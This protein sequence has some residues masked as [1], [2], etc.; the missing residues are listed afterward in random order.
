MKNVVVR[1]KVKPER[2]AEH[3]ALIAR[4]FA[5]LAE[6]RPKDLRYEVFK[7]ADGLS[8]VHLAT[9]SATPNPLTDLEAFKAFAAD[10]KSRLDEGPISSEASAVGC[11]GH[12]IST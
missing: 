8:F 9:H 1:Y 4:V 12:V 11:F 7:L 3:E 2:L 5:Q 6:V 10:V